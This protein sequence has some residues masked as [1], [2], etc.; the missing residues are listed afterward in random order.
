MV[1]YVNTARVIIKKRS[2]S[3]FLFDGRFYFYNK[4]FEHAS[5]ATH[6]LEVMVTVAK[7][8]IVCYLDLKLARHVPRCDF[9]YL[10]LFHFWLNEKIENVYSRREIL[11]F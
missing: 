7:N 3:K 11:K 8:R 10:S 2:G 4:Q 6:V 1:N 5:D 9:S